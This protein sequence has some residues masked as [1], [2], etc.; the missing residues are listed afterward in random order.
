MHARSAFDYA[1]VRV[2]PHVDREEF[3]NAGVVVFCAAHD[4]LAAQIDLDEARLAALA[5]DVDRE[6][7]R[8]HLD[9]IPRTCVGCAEAGAI[10]ALTLRERFHWLVSPRSTML[11]TSAAHVGLV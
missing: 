2:V 4:Y 11:Q 10:G 6:V 7:V 5:S 3:I 8:R 9:A 1:V